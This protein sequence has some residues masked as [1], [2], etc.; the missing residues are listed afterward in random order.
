MNIYSYINTRKQL[1]KREKSSYLLYCILSE[2]PIKTKNYGYRTNNNIDDS[3]DL[4]ED[5]SRTV[6]NNQ[7]KVSGCTSMDSSLESTASEPVR[8]LP[9]IKNLQ[10]FADPQPS[11][12]VSP[13]VRRVLAEFKLDDLV[14][15]AINKGMNTMMQSFALPLMAKIPETL[16][17]DVSRAK[18]CES[19]D[20]DNTILLSQ[21]VLINA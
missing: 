2:Y 4:F 21:Y 9:A 13:V 19:L 8:P 7:M 1:S 12:S 5:S 16:Q 11:T 10:R 14:T 20:L 3:G 18:S 17:P 15:A 6:D